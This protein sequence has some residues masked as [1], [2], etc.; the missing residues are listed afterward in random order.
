MAMGL[1]E[2]FA[3]ITGSA[4]AEFTPCPARR[5][6]SRRIFF[7]GTVW[8]LGVSSPVAGELSFVAIGDWGGESSEEPSTAKQVATAEGFVAIAKALKA[9]FAL[10]MG[11][12]LY[13]HGV[14]SGAEVFHRFQ[15]TFEAVYPRHLP[16]MPFYALAGNHDYGEGE[17]ANISAQVA[18]TQMSEN[19]RFPSLWYKIHR[20]FQAGGER[21]LDLLIIDTV[22]LCGMESIGE[23]GMDVQLEFLGKAAYEGEPGRL[24]SEVAEAQW[25][26]LETELSTST[27]D[28]LWVSGHFPI[29][30]LGIDGSTPCLIERLAPLLRRYG[31]HYISGHDHNLEHIHHEGLDAFVV[32]AGKECC[33]PAVNLD[34]VPPDSARFYVAGAN[35]SES[36]TKLP[37][38]VL[39]G[40]SSL[41]FGA[42]M[43]V[44]T[45]HA[46]DGT[47]LYK[48]QPLPRRM[49]GM[50]AMEKTAST[51]RPSPRASS[52]EFTVRRPVLAVL[53]LFATAIF[54]GSWRGK[55]QFAWS[56]Q[57]PLWAEQHWLP[58]GRHLPLVLGLLVVAS[59][60]F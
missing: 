51:L 56:L 7:L 43:A 58:R 36:R 34:M 21:S 28:Y 40:F 59:S 48:A 52:R 38:P 15:E 6:L 26:W 27:A 60:E 44:V 5:F 2:L 25:R 31:A 46:H 17:A 22:S 37:F 11:D 14:Q 9:D 50:K 49:L 39:G 13:Q 29:W 4:H 10:M 47:A 30:S 55:M 23:E 12:N 20:A 53:A 54:A 24:R 35:G 19:W 8:L 41:T 18:Y 57:R 16:G 32:G 3:S 33:Y 45:L 42:E 1:Y